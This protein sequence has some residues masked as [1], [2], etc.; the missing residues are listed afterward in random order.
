M[1]SRLLIGTLLLA[2]VASL[3]YYLIR[4]GARAGLSVSL[5]HIFGVEKS[6]LTPAGRSQSYYYGREL[7]LR[8]PNIRTPDMQVQ[9]TNV[10]RTLETSEY[11]LKGWYDFRGEPLDG[12]LGSDLVPF[13]ANPQF[14]PPVKL[15]YTPLPV[16]RIVNRRTHESIVRLIPKLVE[17]M[18][19]P[20]QPEPPTEF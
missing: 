13:E 15:S 14:L 4:H 5:P 17:H 3:D 11:F 7:R 12:D 1:L 2:V 19:R 18:H 20:V 9:S 16:K 6:Q 10:E 8:H